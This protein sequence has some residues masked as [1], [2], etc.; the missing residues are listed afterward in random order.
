VTLGARPGAEAAPILVPRVVPAE[1]A[2]PLEEPRRIPDAKPEE[3][4]AAY[5]G[6]EIRPVTPET[7]QVLGIPEG[8]GLVV[9]RV[10][11]G[12]PA[13]AGLERFDVL[14]SV[15]GSAVGDRDALV[16]ALSKAGPGEIVE[17][18]LMRRGKKLSVSL[19]LGSR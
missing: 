4:K 11:E 10:V 1:P 13:T 18:D 6:V 9:E 14:L 7:R 3:A 17:I 5:L 16:D 15:A 19:R 12:S 2:K 8:T